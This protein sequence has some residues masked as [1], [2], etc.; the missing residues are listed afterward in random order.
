MSILQGS[1][2]KTS[3][4]CAK[5]GNEPKV[6]VGD[7]DEVEE[8]DAKVRQQR[9]T[10]NSTKANNDSAAQAARTM[11]TIGQKVSKGVYNISFDV[12]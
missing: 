4:V 8:S 12:C 3:C 1:K 10:R 6:A 9:S 5:D 2:A 11:E 7:K